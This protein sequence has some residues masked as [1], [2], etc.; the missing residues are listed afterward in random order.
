MLGS[1]RT[2][3]D[4]GG[5]DK[6]VIVFGSE[7]LLISGNAGRDGVTGAKIFRHER[8]LLCFLSLMGRQ[9]AIRQFFSRIFHSSH[10]LSHIKNLI[11]TYERNPGSLPEIRTLQSTVSKNVGHLNEV[12][13]GHPA[14]QPQAQADPAVTGALLPGPVPPR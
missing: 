1:T 9:L 11:R 2:A 8:M 14:P 6:E 4:L 10:V 3:F 7:G 13:T 12:P 5:D